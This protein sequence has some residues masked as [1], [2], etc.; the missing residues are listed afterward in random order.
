MRYVGQVHEVAVTLPEPVDELTVTEAEERF[1]AE[2]ER[3]YGAPFPGHSV[4]A[5]SV[6]LAAVAPTPKPTL[7]PELDDS[8]GH[9]VVSRHREVVF[10]SG[11]VQAQL[12]ARQTLQAGDVVTGA[13]IV[14]AADTTIVVP[15]DYAASAERNGSL[16]MRVDN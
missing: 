3:L 7:V 11:P 14:E 12:H 9:G 5:V 13:A 2:H 15:P 8:P 16:I 4:E 10:D 6:R 1:H